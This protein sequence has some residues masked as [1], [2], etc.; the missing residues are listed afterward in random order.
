MNDYKHHDSRSL[1]G[2]DWRKLW[3]VSW[4]NHDGTKGERE[5]KSRVTSDQHVFALKSS[6][7]VARVYV[8]GAE[9]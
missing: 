9:Q 2:N 1:D 4:V 3:V 5:H 7:L 8:D 6:R